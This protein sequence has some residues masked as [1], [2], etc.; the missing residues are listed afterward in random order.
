M[1]NIIQRFR[2]F[3]KRLAAVDN[4]LEKLGTQKMY[5]KLHTYMK[6]V[7]IGWLVSINIVNINDLMWYKD[8]KD[9]MSMKDY[10][11]LI[12]PY[13]TNH[14]FHVNMFMDLLLVTLLWLVL[15]SKYVHAFFDVF[16]NQN[17]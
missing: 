5:C 9:F 15:Y 17:N 1:L 8:T 6:R 11:S 14:H 12:L 7:L 3:I 10:M 13:I 4:T 16:D 2:I